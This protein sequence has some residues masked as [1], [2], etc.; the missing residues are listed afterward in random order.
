MAYNFI[1]KEDNDLFLDTN[2]SKVGSLIRAE[3][4]DDVAAVMRYLKDNFRGEQYEE[5]ISIDPNKNIVKIR[6][7]FVGVLAKEYPSA[8][9]TKA[10]LARVLGRIQRR[11]GERIDTTKLS[12]SFG[13]GSRGQKG[14]KNTGIAFEDDVVNA[15]ELWKQGEPYEPGQIMDKDI[16]KF[17]MELVKEYELTKYSEIQIV[18]EGA[19]NKAR[20]LVVQRGSMYAGSP[21][22]DI[23]KTVTDVTVKGKRGATVDKTV[24]LSLKKGA[25]V[26]YLNAGLGTNFLSGFPISSQTDRI[27]KFNEQFK[28]FASNFGIDLEL[29]RNTFIYKTAPTK[30]LGAYTPS[31]YSARAI[32]QLIASAIGYGFHMVHKFD[33]GHIKHYRVTQS[34]MNQASAL[35][36]TPTI[37]YGGKGQFSRRVIIELETTDYRK[38]EFII[39]NKT[40]AQLP[41]KDLLSMFYYR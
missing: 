36:G 9:Q 12:F 15:F 16:E 6:K 10:E 4:L 30:N 29:F 40:S 8:A 24:Y 25:T 33:N 17:I 26:S 2:A 11:N 7:S 34:Y 20:P 38:I 35:R 28:N 39:R 5:P 31:D 22:N 32:Q 18:P 13:D 1:P 3:L 21:S 41:P 23:G 14:T 37:Y 27:Y 19:M